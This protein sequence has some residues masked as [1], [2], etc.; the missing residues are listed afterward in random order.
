MKCTIKELAQKTNIIEGTIRAW[1]V[2][3][4]VGKE[5]SPDNVNYTNLREKLRKYYNDE[6][7]VEKVGCKIDE[8][9]IVKSERI[10]KAWID[11]AELKE[12]DRIVLHN[13][14]LK[15]ELI[16]SG[17]FHDAVE[18]DVHIFRK[19]TENGYEFKAYTYTQLCSKAIK[20]ERIG[21]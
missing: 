18:G 13:Y 11:A 8:V 20:I 10:Q 16:F 19:P 9:E 21:Y 3:P 4:E 1:V 17:L 12:G 6:Q 14:S 2:K 7:F 15:T 5:Y